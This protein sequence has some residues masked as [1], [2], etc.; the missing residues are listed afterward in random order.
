MIILGY[1]I[2]GCAFS[3]ARTPGECTNSAGTLSFAEIKRIIAAG[4]KV[5]LN[6]AAVVK[7]VVWNNN[8]WVSYDDVELSR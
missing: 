3:S 1:S 8:Q 4:A 6:Q 2:A 7:E 5:T